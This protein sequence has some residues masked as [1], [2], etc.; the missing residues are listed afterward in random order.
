MSHA[1]AKMQGMHAANPTVV[2]A[3][4]K[5]FWMSFMECLSI[6]S[7]SDDMLGQCAVQQA[8]AWDPPCFRDVLRTT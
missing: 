6:R 2:R 3:A 4:L 5:D 1:G 8:E 7:T